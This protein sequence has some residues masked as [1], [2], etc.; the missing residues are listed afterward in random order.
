MIF[1]DVIVDISHEKLDRSFQY[2][3]PEGLENKVYVGVMV[4]IPF[5]KGNRIISGYVIGI[6]HIPAWE[7]DK[8]KE[9]SYVET[10]KVA[11]ESELINLAWFIRENYG[12]TMNQALKT[13]IPV[14]EKTKAVEDRTIT[15]TDSYKNEE[16]QKEIIV[17]WERK[18]AS[19]RLRLVMELKNK[20]HLD[21]AYATNHL[22]CSTALLKDLQEKGIIEVSST[23]VYR[24]PIKY[25]FDITQENQ[26]SD[27]VL[28]Q[29][30]QMIVDDIWNSSDMVHLIHGIT[31]SGKTQ[32]YIELIKQV[33]KE[34]KQAIVMIPEISLTFQTV[35]RFY[36][37]F[38]DRVSIINSKLSKGERFDQFERAKNGG[39]DI[40][41]GPRSAVFTPFSNIGVIIIDEEHESSYK[42]ETIPKYHA[43]ETAIY[44]AQSH[45]A[46]VV[47][48][49]ATPS[50]DAYYKARQGEYVLHTIETRAAGGKMAKVSVVDLREELANGN[51]TIFSA[52]LNELILDRLEKKEQIMLFINRRGYAGF[53][54]C[55]SCGE[56]IKCPHCDV[57]L[58]FHNSG[59]LICHYCG[60]T[61]PM[62]KTCPECDSK[63]IARFGTGTEK[64]EEMVKKFYPKARTL[65][66]DA[67]TTAKKGG[68]EKILRAFS[69]HEADILVGTQMIVKGHD[70]PLVTLVGI[71]AADLSLYASDYRAAERTFQ[72]LTQAEGRAGRKSENGA[73]V[74][75][76]YTPENYSIIAA[77][78]QDYKEF[79]EKEIMYRTLMDY[80]P[81][82]HMM[83]MLVT[84]EAENIGVLFCDKIKEYMEKYIEEK[85][86][87]YTIIGPTSGNIAKI[88]DAYRRVMYIKHVDKEKIIL[89]KNYIEIKMKEIQNY[90]K[91]LIS[92]DLNPMNSY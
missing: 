47:L 78:K 9:I 4:K 20:S 85:E 56:V 87:D 67:D 23:T 91:I 77:A 40:M 55:R 25:V 52:E 64:V 84:S 66:M 60:Y 5:G 12:A 33:I 71:I 38:G 1:A 80:P 44:R 57:S 17:L 10:K 73:A 43:R 46:K 81:V 69:N 45:G 88:K 70:F 35:M 54:S 48:G 29:K 83:A 72:L 53:V 28:N 14:K 19:A 82:A 32:I 68:H 34:G 3:I 15:F 59:K 65:R 7:I 39:L 75:Q 79:Y 21:Y 24:N 41:I 2:I 13:V 61:I 74:I 6:T 26:V 11:V 22:K 63:Y 76:T 18:H 90:D 58:S 42:S 31:G 49:S 8:M 37:V 30:Q 51:K 62:P 89:L 36:S 50:L 92:F 86:E 16:K 27:I